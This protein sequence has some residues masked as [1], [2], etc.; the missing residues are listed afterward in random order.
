[1][2]NTSSAKKATR[3]IARKTAVNKSRRTFMRGQ[4]R[5]MEEA[6]AAGDQTAAAEQFKA[7]QPV[8]MKSASKGII[9]KNTASRKVSR[10]SA[11]VK[12]LGA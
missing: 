8:I 6:I 3:K 4:L 11:R 10:L 7:V 1:M 2:A 12:A 5:L 9:H